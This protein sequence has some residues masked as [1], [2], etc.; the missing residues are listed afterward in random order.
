MAT[1]GENT[2]VAYR[3]DWIYCLLLLVRY[4]FRVEINN[5]V[6]DCGCGGLWAVS[7]PVSEKEKLRLRHYPSRNVVT[8]CRLPSCARL[9]RARAPVPTQAQ[10]ASG[11]GV[12]DYRLD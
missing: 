8:V 12:F 7:L 2:Q 1:F 10:L 5:R 6:R 9:R 4:L 3:A 11:W